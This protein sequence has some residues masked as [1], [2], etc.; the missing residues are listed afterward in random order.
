MIWER[1]IIL[2]NNLNHYFVEGECEKR[3]ISEI[4]CKKLL[5]CG[6]KCC[7]VEGEKICP[8]CI[9]H[10]CPFKIAGTEK[11]TICL[12]GLKEDSEISL[13]GRHSVNLRTVFLEKSTCKE[14][15]R[16]EKYKK[17]Q[18]QPS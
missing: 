2:I 15:F 3:F 7:G 10:E 14:I 1:K 16:C 4:C 9:N 18:P 12:E 17:I 8:Q 13:T 5:P 6:H 11:C